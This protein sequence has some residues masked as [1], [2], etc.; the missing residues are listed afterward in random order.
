M[1]ARNSPGYRP[2]KSSERLMINI[3]IEDGG[4]PY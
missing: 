1:A 2:A 4:R 3:D